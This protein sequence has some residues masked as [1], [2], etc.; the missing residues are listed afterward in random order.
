MLVHVVAEVDG[1]AAAAEATARVANGDEQAVLTHVLVAAAADP[2][3]QAALAV[4]DPLRGADHLPPI[5]AAV[6]DGLRTHP[7]AS[8]RRLASAST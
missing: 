7:S 6:R 4:A 5:A 2:G 1:A 8:V 3:R